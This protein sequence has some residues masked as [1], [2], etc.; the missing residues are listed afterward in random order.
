MR[1]FSCHGAA[2]GSTRKATR[3]G[4]GVNFGI[5]FQ[6]GMILQE[7]RC[8]DIGGVSFGAVFAV[9]ARRLLSMRPRLSKPGEM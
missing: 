3:K 9:L 1:L 7:P 2:S 4:F 5:K 8:P 6:S